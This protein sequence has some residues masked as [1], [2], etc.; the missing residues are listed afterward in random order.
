MADKKRILVTGGGTFLGDNIAAALLAEGANVTLLVRPGT[1]DRL[2][3][4]ARRVRWWSADVWDTASL[5]GRARGH[6]LVINTVGSLIADPS[7]GLSHHRLNFVSARNIA[8]MCVS[9]GVPE[10]ILVSSTW[11]PW[12]SRSYIRSK[13][14]AER[15]VVRVGVRGTVIRAPLTY[16]R[17][18]QRSPFFALMTLLGSVPPVS[19]LGFG[20][21]APMPVDV[22]ARGVARIAMSDQRTKSFYYASDLRRL[23]TRDELSR[24][25]IDTPP[26]P[27]QQ[28]PPPTQAAPSGEE[29]QQPRRSAFDFIDEDV[30]F[31]WTPPIDSD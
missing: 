7:K 2:G 10:M 27:P 25:L 14:E 16:V 22:L 30:P 21:I 3:E 13:R 26:L 1:E 5:R 20:K 17:L 12:M 18:Q 4:L 23:N 6:Q 19:W 11:A 15:Y 29:T 24:D 9:D 8:A 28:P 31:G